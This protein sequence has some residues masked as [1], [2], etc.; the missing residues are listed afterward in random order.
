M[1]V[2]VQC[3]QTMQVGIENDFIGPFEPFTDDVLILN[4]RIAPEFA[5]CLPSGSPNATDTMAEFANDLNA[6]MNDAIYRKFQPDFEYFGY[7]ISS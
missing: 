1:A 4:G 7:S 6:E 2:R 5:T 3:Y